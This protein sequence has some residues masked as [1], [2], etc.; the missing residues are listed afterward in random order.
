MKFNYNS[1]FE[2]ALNQLRSEGRYRVFNNI[3]RKSGE[4]PKAVFNNELGI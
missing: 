3:T 4:F 2:N 1:I